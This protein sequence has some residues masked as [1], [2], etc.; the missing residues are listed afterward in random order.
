MA[1]ALRTN[2]LLCYASDGLDQRQHPLTPCGKDGSAALF[3]SIDEFSFLVVG[4]DADPEFAA[5]VEE[6]SHVGHKD[7][8]VTDDSIDG[9]RLIA[10]CFGSQRHID[11][12]Q[13]HVG[14]KRKGHV[15]NHQLSVGEIEQRAPGGAE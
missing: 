6:D 12:R 3:K 5:V 10:V 7:L 14:Y 13:S 2:T 9:K 15:V 4:A 8:F 11:G 1:T